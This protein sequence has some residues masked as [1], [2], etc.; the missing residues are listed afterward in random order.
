[1][2][3]FIK[4]CNRAKELC[5]LKANKNAVATGI[6]K[7]YFFI[8]V[9]YSQVKIKFSHIKWKEDVRDYIKIHLKNAAK[10][11]LLRNN[12]KAMEEQ[13]PRS[14]F[15]RIHR[16]YFVAIESIT[17]VR[18]SSVFIDDMELRLV[19]PIETLLRNFYRV[20]MFEFLSAK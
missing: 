6:V 9:D 18:K 19:R 7:D 15:V 2:D 1:M 11:I 4:A 8:N 3:R 13:L 20:W 14:R 16:S 17:A 12:L 10:P 5:G